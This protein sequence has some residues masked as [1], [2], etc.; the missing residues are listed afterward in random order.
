MLGV[1]ALTYAPCYTAWRI[2]QC[3]QKCSLKPGV[4]NE[5]RAG[6]RASLFRFRTTVYAV[7]PLASRAY[8]TAFY[9]AVNSKKNT[10]QA[11][12]PHTLRSGLGCSKRCTGHAGAHRTD[13]GAQ[14]TP[15]PRTRHRL[16]PDR[17][18][19]HTKTIGHPAPDPRTAIHS[20]SRLISLLLGTPLSF[21]SLCSWSCSRHRR[22]RRRRRR[23]HP[24]ASLF[25]RAHPSIWMLTSY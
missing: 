21:N 14:R 17:A 2:G 22:L 18:H 16:A 6:R 3:I 5:N 9:T 13:S 1:T 10:A 23:R 20:P 15:V 4:K 7:R 12:Q 19:V 8:G 24:L 25:A 11:S